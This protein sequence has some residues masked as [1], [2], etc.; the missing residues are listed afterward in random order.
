MR[1]VVLDDY[2]EPMSNK[3]LGAEGLY[4][5]GSNPSFYHGLANGTVGVGQDA[6]KTAGIYLSH[7]SGFNIV[8]KNNNRFE[9]HDGAAF[10]A[11]PRR[12]TNHEEILYPPSAA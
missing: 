10:N 8:V 1:I 5:V 2:R 9:E 12:R 4:T 3:T 7:M 6:I 11:F